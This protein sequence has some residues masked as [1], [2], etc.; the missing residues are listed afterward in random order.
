M[1]EVISLAILFCCLMLTACDQ[2][3]RKEQ[4]VQSQAKQPP[5][6]A[7][8]TNERLDPPKPPTLPGEKSELYTVKRVRAIG[9]DPHVCH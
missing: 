5:A 7:R 3:G 4:P 8:D 2:L 1:S 6:Q 9:T